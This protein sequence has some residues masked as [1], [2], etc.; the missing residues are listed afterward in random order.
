M[1]WKF[2]NVEHTQTRT[3]HNILYRHKRQIKEVLMINRIELH[4]I[5][6]PQQ[7]WE[8]KGGNSGSSE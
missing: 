5:D 1:G 6:Q 3:F 7:V 8:L 4:L 2:D